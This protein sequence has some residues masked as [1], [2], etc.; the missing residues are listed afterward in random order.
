MPLPAMKRKAVSHVTQL[1]E[2]DCAAAPP[3]PSQ[4]VNFYAVETTSDK[5]AVRSRSLQAVVEG[6]EV[7][8]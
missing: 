3:L 2:S 1:S 7:N 5:A 6:T 4:K 8:K